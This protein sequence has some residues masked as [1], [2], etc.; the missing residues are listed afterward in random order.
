[1]IEFIDKDPSNLTFE[2]INDIFTAYTLR[3]YLNSIELI[4]IKSIVHNREDDL[5]IR[6]W[7]DKIFFSDLNLRVIYYQDNIEFPRILLQTIDGHINFEEHFL[8]MNL[9]Q[10]FTENHSKY[11]FIYFNL[12]ANKNF[13]LKQL[14]NNQTELYYRS[15]RQISPSEYQ[16]HLTTMAIK[17]SISDTIIH[18]NNNTKLFFPSTEK[19][20]IINIHFWPIYHE[21]LE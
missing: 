2:I 14:S 5:I 20:Q 11:Q 3:T 10:L 16:I 12:I 8:T 13:Y 19:L 7:D 1:K 17:E 4:L 9:G 15:F 6:V 18:N 21:M